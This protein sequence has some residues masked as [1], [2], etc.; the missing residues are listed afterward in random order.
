[1]ATISVREYEERDRDACNGLWL[2]LTQHHRDIYEDETIGGGDPTRWF[3]T[4]LEEKKPG[5]VWVAELDGRV[6]GFVGAISIHDGLRY[7]LEPIVVAKESRSN[8]VGSALAQT[9]IEAARNAGLRG[10]EVYPVARN[11]RAIQFFHR[12]G[13]DALGQLELVLD[14]AKPERWR[15]GEQLAGRDF[16]V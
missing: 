12:H 7:E 14:L 13:F 15:P 11:A 5:D 1:V 6:I 4:Y 2:Q 9:V 16:R 8:G 3:D 10:V